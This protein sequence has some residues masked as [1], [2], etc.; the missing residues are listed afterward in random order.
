MTAADQVTVLNQMAAQMHC[1]VAAI[2]SGVDVSSAA[3]AAPEVR[4]D[5]GGGTKGLVRGVTAAA[6]SDWAPSKWVSMVRAR[7]SAS[8]HG[9]DKALNQS[10][11]PL[12]NTVSVAADKNAQIRDLAERNRELQQELSVTRSQHKAALEAADAKLREVQKLVQELQWEGDER[13]ARQEATTLE[14]QRRVS[15]HEAELEE[16]DAALA[17]KDAELLDLRAL[18]ASSRRSSDDRDKV[19]AAEKLRSPSCSPRT[20][21]RGNRPK[22]T[23]IEATY[24]ESQ[25]QLPVEYVQGPWWPSSPGKP[26]PVAPPPVASKASASPVKETATGAD[27]KMQS[28][29]PPTPPTEPATPPT[30]TVPTPPTERSRGLVPRRPR[31]HTDPAAISTA[32]CTL[33]RT[34]R[35]SAHTAQYHSDRCAATGMLLNL[36]PCGACT[37]LESPSRRKSDNERWAALRRSDG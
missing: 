24:T 22:S 31:R 37:D 35:A 25:A 34:R 32:Q 13:K 28:E 7:R 16:H 2:P 23:G 27:E 15:Q 14:L 9:E 30:E 4:H 1:I 29:E 11:M 26:T 18:Q 33:A 21:R 20:L 36:C 12:P 3:K 6:V 19:A 17:K 5:H 8:S 10:R